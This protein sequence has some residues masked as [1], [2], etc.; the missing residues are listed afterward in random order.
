[1]CLRLPVVLRDFSAAA[2]GAAI[3][4][5]IPD[6]TARPPPEAAVGANYARSGPPSVSDSAGTLYVT[7]LTVVVIASIK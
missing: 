4:Y 7:P 3:T 5:L 2:P 1:M 6:Q